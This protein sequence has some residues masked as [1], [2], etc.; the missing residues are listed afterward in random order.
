MRHRHRTFGSL[1]IVSLTLAT[2]ASAQSVRQAS[3]RSNVGVIRFTNSGAPAAQAAFLRG[4][5]QLHNFEYREAAQ[6]FQ[7][8]ER[9]DPKFALPHWFEAMTHSPILWNVDDPPAARAVLARL[10]PTASERLAK[11]ATDR[12]RSFGAAVE[13][14]YADTTLTART[15]A[16]ADSLSALAQRDTTD[17]EASA[18]AAL[19]N[20]MYVYQRDISPSAHEANARRAIAFAERVYRDSPR[21][22]GAAHYLIHASDML[23]AYTPRALQPAF[24]YA[25]IAPAAEHA[26]HMPAHVFLKD[27]LWHD[28]VASNERAW[29]ASVA[30]AGREHRLPTQ[31]DYHDFTWLQYAYLQEGRW[32]AARA[33]IDSARKM[34]APYDSGSTFTIDAHYAA[35]FLTFAYANETDHWVDGPSGSPVSTMLGPVAARERERGQMTSTNFARTAA[36]LMRGD[37]SV[38]PAARAYVDSGLRRLELEAIIAERRGDREQAVALWRRA[39]LRDTSLLGGPPR[40][41]IARERLAAAL[42]AMGRATDAAAEYEHAL[43]NTPGRST[44]L[45]GLARARLAM[46]DTTGSAVAYTH[47]LENWSHADADLPAL[48]EA[49]RGAARAT[50][51]KVVNTEAAI[52]KQR[53]WF[54]NGALMLEGFLFKPAGNGPFPTVVWNHGSERT[55]GAGPQFDSVAGV[56]V[57][58]G[59]VV[60]APVRRGHDESEG[61]HI[62]VVRGRVAGAQGQQAGDAL[63]TRLL[64]TDQLS[65][66]LAGLSYLKRLPFVDTTR[67]V[68]AG[69]SFGGIQTLL[70]AEGNRGFKA[71]L[72]LSPAADNWNH[73]APLRARLEAGIA[74]I[75]IPVFL[76]QP[77]RDASLRPARELGAEFTRLKKDYRG[78]VWPD[79]L[80]AREAAHCF[81]GANGMH[82]WAAEGVAFFDSVLARKR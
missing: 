14:L 35:D 52:A 45:L 57:P 5:A 68:V 29:K 63:A 71:A 47:L 51:T 39:A 76:I 22:P 40:S 36:A 10:A 7:E 31:L 73:N 9:A 70:A 20:L 62:G 50:P 6:A 4:I 69:C 60:F 80:S 16:F 23:N 65:D 25:Y 48:S 44:V 75:D 1:A 12:E 17:L 77:P 19:G 32:H 54:K 15:K 13:A 79:T 11:A 41:L 27:G 26:L 46:G 55:P 59:Y 58:H 3:E 67:L 61:E 30:E 81:G 78:K 74:K 8:A 38:I 42:L 56:F 37:T 2:S 66:Q 64:A 28:M 34:I 43:K 49:R 24:D 18:F 53:V 21:H 82:V 33:M 72:P